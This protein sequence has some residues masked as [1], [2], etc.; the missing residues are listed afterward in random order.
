MAFA[1]PTQYPEWASDPLLV[2]PE[3]GQ[4]NVVD[5][6]T[7]ATGLKPEGW[8]FKQKPPRAWFNWMHNLYYNWIG[9]FDESIDAIVQSIIDLGSDDI[10]NDSTTT[11]TTVSD[12]LETI[13]QTGGSV[14]VSVPIAYFDTPLSFNIDWIKQQNRVTIFIPRAFGTQ[15]SETGNYAIEPDTV[16]PTEM[17]NSSTN[18]K[19]V[20]DVNNNGT[21]EAGS[22]VLPSGT[23]TSMVVNAYSGAFSGNK[24]IESSYITYTV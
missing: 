2:D 22:I 3:S 19:Y 5:P 16:W 13:G 1:K 20:V 4:N 21:H 7:V 14:S 11:G 9:Y 6:D 10:A 8:K 23:T 15:A 24:G 12:A 17:I 18:A